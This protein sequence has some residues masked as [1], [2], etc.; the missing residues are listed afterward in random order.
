MMSRI[1]ALIKKDIRFNWKIIIGVLIGVTIFVPL[2]WADYKIEGVWDLDYKWL[3]CWFICAAGVLAVNPGLRTEQGASTNVFL[4]ALPFTMKELFLSKIIENVVY[5]VL[6]AGILTAGILLFGYPIE[7]QYLL[8]GVPV[9][10]FCNTIYVSIHYLAGFNK[11]QLFLLSA[12][13]IPELVGG[14]MGVDLAVMTFFTK[15]DVS[16]CAS[17]VMLILSLTM[18]LLMCMKK[19]RL[20]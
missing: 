6:V 2:N 16:A 13:L 10:I 4:A 17:I 9:S 19:R 18:V 20:L 12:L 1:L 14:W 7:L 15:P 3:W 11:A 5:T 8:L